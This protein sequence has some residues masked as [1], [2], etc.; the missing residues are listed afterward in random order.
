MV[1]LI[2]WVSKNL[3]RP[4]EYFLK[5]KNL[6]QSLNSA[7]HYQKK[8]K[9]I[10]RKIKEL[11]DI[12][13]HRKIKKEESCLKQMLRFARKRRTKTKTLTTSSLSRLNT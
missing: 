1:Q 9:E 2:L 8:M 6:K 4:K 10:D 7:S 11:Q 13:T 3:I 12:P 5:L